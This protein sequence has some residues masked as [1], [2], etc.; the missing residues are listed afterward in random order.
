[1]CRVVLHTNRLI[2]FFKKHL[3]RASLKVAYEGVLIE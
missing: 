3:V 1:M 2:P